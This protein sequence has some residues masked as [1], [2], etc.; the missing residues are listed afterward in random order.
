MVVETSNISGKVILNKDL[1][2]FRTEFQAIEL[3]EKMQRMLYNDEE[4]NGGKGFIDMMSI[5]QI[6]PFITGMV[7]GQPHAFSFVLLSYFANCLGYDVEI[8]FKKRMNKDAKRTG[9]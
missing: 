3:A 9:N 7:S 5:P 6:V 1:L 2:E 4:F 8:T